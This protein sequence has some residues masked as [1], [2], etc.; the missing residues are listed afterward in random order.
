MDEPRKGHYRVHPVLVSHVRNKYGP[1]FGTS[2]P[3]VLGHKGSR[4]GVDEDSFSSKSL[5]PRVRVGLRVPKEES[6][7]PEMRR[8]V[9]GTRKIDGTTDLNGLVTKDG[10]PVLTGGCP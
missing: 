7:G 6:V 5:V 9:D 2:E 8:Q 3:R 10:T 4:S 1:K